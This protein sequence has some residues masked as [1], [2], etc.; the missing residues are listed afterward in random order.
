MHH[1]PTSRI[2]LTRTST[3]RNAMGAAGCLLGLALAGCGG[4]SA[5]SSVSMPTQSAST[6]PNTI[7]LNEWTVGVPSVTVKPSSNTYTVT[8]TGSI[9]HELLVFRSNLAPSAYP[10]KDGGIDEEGASITKISDGDNLAAGASQR[11]TVDLTQPGKYLFVCNL[12]SHFMMGMYAVV[13][14]A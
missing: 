9:P 13:T 3:A 10:M 7:T 6:A 1:H 8:N 2:R 11:R 14:V 5:T 12:P 4:A